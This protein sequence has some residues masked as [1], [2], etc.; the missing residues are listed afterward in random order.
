MSLVTNPRHVVEVYPAIKKM[1]PDGG[2]GIGWSDEPL[3][4]RGNVQPL[5]SDNLNRT[6]STRDEYYGETLATTAVITTPPGTW[7]KARQSLPEELREGFPIDA[8]VVFDP[9]KYTTVLGC[10]PLRAARRWFTRSTRVR[11]CSVWDGTLSTIR[12][13]CTE[14]TTYIVSSWK[15]RSNGTTRWYRALRL[16]RSA[17]Q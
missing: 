14:A 4:I 6:A 7:D 12:W 10:A 3:L 8:L 16:E 17:H 15:E 13:R 5:A 1:M 9:G 2:G 11:C